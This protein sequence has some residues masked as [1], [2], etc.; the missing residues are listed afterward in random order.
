MDLKLINQLIRED[1]IVKLRTIGGQEMR[2]LIKLGIVPEVIELTDFEV[3]ASGVAK[4]KPV[5]FLNRAAIESIQS[6]GSL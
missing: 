6:I 3:N 1:S 4:A 5:V 2:G